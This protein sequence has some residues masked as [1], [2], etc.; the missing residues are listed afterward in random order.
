MTPAVF[1]AIGCVV[2]AAGSSARF[3]ENKLTAEL[4]GV[5]LIERALGAVP[6]AL[7]ARLVVVTGHAAVAQAARR[8]GFEVI[9]NCHP[10]W[11]ASY[12]VRLATQAMQACDAILFLVADQPRLT[13][14]SVAQIVERWRKNKSR[15]VGAASGGK[16]ANPNIFPKR[17][18]SELLALEGDRGGSAVIARHELDYLPVELPPLEVRDCDTKQAL[19]ALRAQSGKNPREN[20]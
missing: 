11:G 2:M 7:F 5:P 6:N 1:P 3:G 15:I 17:F 9:E 16:R 4:D 18:F 13:R 14:T 20:L 8:H 10:E 19:A 12:T